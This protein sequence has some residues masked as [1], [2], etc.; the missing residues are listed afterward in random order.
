M[1]INQLLFLFNLIYLFKTKNKIVNLKSFFNVNLILNQ[2]KIFKI[3]DA[4]QIEM[5]YLVNI[6][7]NIAFEL[8]RLFRQDLKNYKYKKDF[9]SLKI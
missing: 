3:K 9:L 5:F 8:I 2:L 4:N 7:Q 6:F 1:K